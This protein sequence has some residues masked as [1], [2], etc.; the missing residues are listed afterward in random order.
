MTLQAGTRLGPYEIVA[1]LG[2]GGMGEVYRARDTR[3]GRDV[4]IKILP[5]HLM[6][7]ADAKQRFEREARAVSSLNHA[8]I[9]TLHDIGHQDGTDFLVM[10]LLEGETLAKRLEKGPLVGAELLR[11]AIEI[12]DALEKAH[13]QGVIHRDLKP[14]NIMLT[15]SGAKLLDFGLAKSAIAGAGAA[16]P[17]SSLTQSLNSAGQTPTEPLTARGTVVGTFQY[18]APEQMEGK[19][20]DARSDIFSFGT[21]LYE[22]ATGRRAFEGKTTASVIAAILEREPPAISSVQPMSPPAL[23]RVVKVCL[24]KDPDER[25]QSMHDVKLQLEWIRDGGSQAGVAAP[26][27]AHRKNRERVAWAVAAALA[28]IAAL[29]AYGFIARAPQ[30]VSVSA[31]ILPPEKTT[32]T[33]MNDDA[34][35][36]LVLSKDG[37]ELAFVAEGTNGDRSLYV[38]SPADKDARMI[39]DTDG[40][41]YPFWSPD[42]ESLGFYSNG[43]LR[44][45]AVNGGPPVE[46]CD[47]ERM[48]GGTWLPDDT[49]LFTPDITAGIFRVSASPGSTP[50]EITRTSSAQDTNRWP[51]ILPDGKHFLYL[52]SSHS[53]PQASAQNGI[54][55]ASLDGKENRF[56]MPAQSNVVYA[57]GELLF[58][59][60]G[61]LL[62]RSFDPSTGKIGGEPVAL[63]QNVSFNVSSWRAAFDASSNGALI[64]Q[65]TNG[66]GGVKLL[67]MDR[68]GKVEQT[69]N[70]TDP[71]SNVR[72]SSD[73]RKLA[74]QSRGGAQGYNIWILNLE[75]GT[76][77]RL[78]F[79]YTTE[80]F[81]WS[82]DGKSLY[83]VHVAYSPGKGSA[84]TYEIH[85]QNVD[86]SG[87]DQMLFESKDRFYVSSV[88]RD[89]SKL[90]LVEPFGSLPLTTGIMDVGPN[91]EPKPLL[92]EPVAAFRAGFSPDSKWVLYISAETRRY[93]LYA[94]STGGGDGQQLTSTG[95]L[96]WSWRADG[97]AIDYSTAEGSIYEMPVTE[98]PKTL[99]VGAPRLLFDAHVPST[100]QYTRQLWD[101]TSD[102]QR[103]VVVASSENSNGAL[104]ELITNWPVLVKKQ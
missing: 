47:A 30:P 27:V 53:N 32:F 7:M 42:G 43:K 78:T 83:Y 88:S 35:G 34:A 71:L 61:T 93:E 95:A 80:G 90:L 92:K 45:V 79:G 26:V 9:C 57:H 6:E 82:G 96:Y 11:I 51:Y 94:V 101:A 18:M 50:V 12:A 72:F 85:R 17:L 76:R 91:A 62:A 74:I 89:D 56:V 36:P 65:P 73:G 46:I 86:G 21:V 55:F 14:G 103:F 41:E 87:R 104:A 4:A 67:V 77:M 75:K 23:D 52:A 3:L 44:R 10:E 69:I 2:A 16:P 29:L 64:Y 84:P 31:E 66:L 19:E 49:I 68:D 15:K 100:D 33:L 13:R 1:P 37:K 70:E 28:I 58:V 54:Y 24:A 98:T 81:C 22:I 25:F 20:T 63:A 48:R 40:A 60:D 102:G 59:Q 8:H 97:K 5:Q 39:P 38:R 99:T